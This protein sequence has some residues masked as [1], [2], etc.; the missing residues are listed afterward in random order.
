MSTALEMTNML[1]S[2]LLTRKSVEVE[3]LELILEMREHNLRKAEVSLEVRKGRVEA[4]IKAVR[5]YQE[6]NAIIIPG[7]YFNQL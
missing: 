5:K 7:K 4:L 1:I 3:S 2:Q 6:K